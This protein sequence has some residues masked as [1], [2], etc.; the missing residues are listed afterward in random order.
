M[1]DWA[2]EFWKTG[3]NANK[4]TFILIGAVVGVLATILIK[5][6][7]F[8]NLVKFSKWFLKGSILLTTATK[9][10]TAKKVKGIKK[11][12]KYKRTIKLIEKKEIDVP[13][14]FLFNKSEEKNPELKKVFE[15]I[16]SEEIKAPPGYHANKFLKENPQLFEN[17]AKEIANRPPPHIKMAD[18]SVKPIEYFDKTKK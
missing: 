18:L 5:D 14:N 12:R 4:L 2:I 8:V 3:E 6:I 15:M 17:L 11:K 1:P 7:I 10:R 9:E 13:K 16:D